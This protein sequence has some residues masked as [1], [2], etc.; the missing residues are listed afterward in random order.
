MNIVYGAVLFILLSQPP[1]IPKG[2]RT[3]RE[4]VV[5]WDTVVT[6]QIH[7]CDGKVLR[8]TVT[9]ITKRILKP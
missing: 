7:K 6:I 8:D 1:L 9:T 4:R 3:E 2:Y 5:V